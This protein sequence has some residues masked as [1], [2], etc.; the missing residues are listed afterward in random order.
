[1]NIVIDCPGTRWSAIIR[2]RT[3]KTRAAIQSELNWNWLRSPNWYPTG[4][5]PSSWVI[6]QSASGHSI[7]SVF[8]FN[9]INFANWY[10]VIVV[11]SITNWARARKNLNTGDR[12][13]ILSSYNVVFISDEPNVRAAGRTMANCLWALNCE[14]DEKCLK[15]SLHCARTLSPFACFFLFAF[16]SHST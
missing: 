8:N 16:S 3:V 9:K 4:N 11:W 12:A 14:K 6:K 5:T 7:Q 2:M 10:S 13:I 15:Q 1:M